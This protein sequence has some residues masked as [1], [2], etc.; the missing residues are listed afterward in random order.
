MLSVV[1]I[2][3][4]DAQLDLIGWLFQSYQEIQNSFLRFVEGYCFF[5]WLI[6]TVALKIK[7]YLL[8][9]FIRW[10]GGTNNHHCPNIQQLFSLVH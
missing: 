6:I 5:L 8:T 7:P 9:L 2:I 4:D 10:G 1:K 3:I